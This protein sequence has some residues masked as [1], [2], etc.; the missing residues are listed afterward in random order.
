MTGSTISSISAAI[1]APPPSIEPP[2]RKPFRPG[3]WSPAWPPRHNRPCAQAAPHAPS[4]LNL[5]KLTVPGQVL[6][7][8]P[9]GVPAVKASCVSRNLE[10]AFALAAQR[11]IRGTGGLL[12]GAIRRTI[13]H[14]TCP[15]DT[16]II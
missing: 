5:I 12:E 11:R 2:E 4:R 14:G 1:T 9:D 8:T 15:N 16:N 3:P 6:T 7:G 10:R 13:S